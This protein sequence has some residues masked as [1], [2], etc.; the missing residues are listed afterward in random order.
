MIDPK[1]DGETD[2]RTGK[3]TEQQKMDPKVTPSRSLELELVGVVRPERDIHC[4][5]TGIEFEGRYL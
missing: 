3:K 1:R 5:A 2:V 4:R